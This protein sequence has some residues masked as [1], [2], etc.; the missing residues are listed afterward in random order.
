[1]RGGEGVSKGLVP[2]KKFLRAEKDP[3][4]FRL[5]LGAGRK[6]RGDERMNYQKGGYVRGTQDFPQARSPSRYWEKRGAGWEHQETMKKKHR[7]RELEEERE[8]KERKEMT[9]GVVVD[10]K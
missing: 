5:L 3:A 1:M 4:V 8:W 6:T 10:G 2:S 9:T 7:P